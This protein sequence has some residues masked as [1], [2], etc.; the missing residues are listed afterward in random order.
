MRCACAA[1]AS[2][3]RHWATGSTFAAAARASAVSAASTVAGG[4]ASSA[5][6]STT[7]AS[8]ADDVDAGVVQAGSDP[9]NM[10]TYAATLTPRR[11]PPL[12]PPVPPLT[13][14][15]GSTDLLRTRTRRSRSFVR[16]SA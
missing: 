8:G 2:S 1:S 10:R 14:P 7:C 11:P 5:W 9:Q 6:A 13:M 16:G 12:L 3:R 15:A 4:A